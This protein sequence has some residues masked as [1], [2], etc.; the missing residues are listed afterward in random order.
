MTTWVI[1]SCVCV[2]CKRAHCSV[3]CHKSAHCRN[4]AVKSIRVD[5]VMLQLVKNLRILLTVS[6]AVYMAEACRG[7]A[8][9]FNVQ[10]R[11]RGDLRCI[12]ACSLPCRAYNKLT[13]SAL[14]WQTEA[15]SET[16]SLK[17]AIANKALKGLG[18]LHQ[19]VTS[20][21]KTA[22]GGNA[23]SPIVIPPPVAPLPWTSQQ[24]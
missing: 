3:V 19:R 10:Q 6:L 2:V 5:R 14:K 9:G 18:T 23:D 4:A 24:D 20:A 16:V 22:A 11:W 8:E 15:P 1:C 12:H 13:S 21:D 17:Q 7:K